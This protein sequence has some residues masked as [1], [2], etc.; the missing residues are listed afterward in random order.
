[1]AAQAAQIASLS[2]LSN[3]RIGVIPLTAR[4]GDIPLHGYEI[5]DERLVTIGLTPSRPG[6]APRDVDIVV[7]AV[8]SDK[9]VVPS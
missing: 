5:F 6:H 1:M 3:V 2:T 9:V 4:P 7:M 8:D